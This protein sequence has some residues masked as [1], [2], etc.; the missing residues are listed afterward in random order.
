M[1]MRVYNRET[2]EIIEEKE[3]QKELLEFL[4]NTI[5]GRILLKLWVSRPIFSKIK[6]YY[7]KSEDSKKAI[8]PFIDKYDIDLQ[9]QDY[10]K[11]NSF[12]EFF[13]RRKK[14]EFEKS[15]GVLISPADAK[16]TVYKITNDLRFDI[17]Q[18]NYNVF[19]II[20][21]ENLSEQ[22]K[23]GYCFVFRLAVS[24]YHRYIYIDSGKLVSIKKIKGLL[25]TV[26]P[27]SNKY[28]VFC[29]NS[30]EVSLLRTDNLG[31]IVQVEV[32]ALL[33]GCIRNNKKDIFEKGEEKGYFEYGG[34][35]IILLLKDNIEIDK[36]ILDYN[37]KGIEVKVNIGE[38][39]GIVKEN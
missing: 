29:R 27:I 15:S 34:S 19:E 31:D 26:R 7:R 4:Y 25:H 30:R 12:N 6:G 14:F 18:S 38:K 1:Y 16:L 35:T 32:G 5:L 21:D 39:I 2:K 33:V 23:N 10:T 37:S 20:E 3:Y 28:R 36:D 8:K 9:G 11:F 17:K 22:Y 24:D 13:I